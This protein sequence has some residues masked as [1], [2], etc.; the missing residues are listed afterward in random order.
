M[1]TDK[2]NVKLAFCHGVSSTLTFMP[3]GYAIP[4]AGNASVEGGSSKEHL[5]LASF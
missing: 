4:I 3:H 2:R 5:H 1:K